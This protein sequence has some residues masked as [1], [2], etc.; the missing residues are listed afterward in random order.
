MFLI[1]K[2]QTETTEDIRHF[3]ETL[4]SEVYGGRPEWL[5]Y[6]LRESYNFKGREFIQMFCRAGSVHA[7][8]RLRAA[9]GDGIGRDILQLG[10]RDGQS[11]AWLLHHGQESE[12][13]SDEVER[14][15]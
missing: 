3:L 14:V 8:L 13:D 11:R 10:S 4:V 6:D 15:G 5:E 1:E 12:H 7:R 2:L 9:T